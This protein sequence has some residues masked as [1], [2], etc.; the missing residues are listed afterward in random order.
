[1][2]HSLLLYAVLASQATTQ[3]ATVMLWQLEQPFEG[4]PKL[5][6]G[7]APNAYFVHPELI[8]A[9]PFDAANE[10]ISQN[11]Y[12]EVKTNLRIATAA[13]YDFEVRT[14]TKLRMTLSGETMLNTTDPVFEVVPGVYRGQY[15]LPVGRSGLALFLMHND[16]DLQLEVRWKASNESEFRTIDPSLLTTDAGQTFV[17]SPGLKRANLGAPTTRPGDRRPL[18]QVH[19]S[20][21]LEEFRGED[22]RPAVGG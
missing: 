21:L 2:I 19:P 16:G 8:L 14:N 3:G 10:P 1:M 11:L 15:R 6:E 7:Q 20:F 12:G 13:T 18:D 5:V 22:F 9:G 17:V 4:I